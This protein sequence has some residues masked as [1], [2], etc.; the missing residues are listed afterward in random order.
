MRKKLD[1]TKHVESKNIIGYVKV[2]ILM[3]LKSPWLKNVFLVKD[4]RFCIHGFHI[5]PRNYEP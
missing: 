3:D 4:I 1:P 2:K 5:I